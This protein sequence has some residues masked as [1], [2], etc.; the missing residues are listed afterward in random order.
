MGLGTCTSL[1]GRLLL[2]QRPPDPYHSPARTSRVRHRLRIE[3]S[4]SSASCLWVAA[5]CA[6]RREYGAATTTLTRQSGRAAASSHVLMELWIASLPPP[7]N[8]LIESHV[9][10]IKKSFFIPHLHYRIFLQVREEDHHAHVHF[11]SNTSCQPNR[12]SKSVNFSK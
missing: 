5:C 1:P 6:G 3:V 2:I 10:N 4:S 9:T 11:Y 8:N 12:K 7:V